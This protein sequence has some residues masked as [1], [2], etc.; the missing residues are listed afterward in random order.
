MIVAGPDFD[1]DAD[2]RRLAMATT[3]IESPATPS[4]AIASTSAPPTLEV[5]GGAWKPLPG[6]TGEAVDLTPLLSETPYGPVRSFVGAQAQEDLLKRLKAPCVLHIATHGYFVA[7]FPEAVPAREDGL[8]RGRMFGSAV[9]FSR[10][11]RS[12]NPLLHSGI[13]LAGAN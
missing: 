2:A 13:V 12:N 7:D 11:R 6:A 10:L 4:L 5:R 1:V 9:G 3:G 8:T